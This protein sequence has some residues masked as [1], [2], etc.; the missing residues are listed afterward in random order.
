MKIEFDDQDLQRITS[1][2]IEGLKPLLS[3]KGEN[4]TND[5]I[6]DVPGICKYLNVSTHWVYERTHLNEI[7]YYKLSNKQLR[8]RKKD[9]DQWLNSLKT[10]AINEY[11]GMKRRS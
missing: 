10:P 7:P 6:I 11:R 9:I 1:A 2:V 8:F 3:D 4:R 5:T